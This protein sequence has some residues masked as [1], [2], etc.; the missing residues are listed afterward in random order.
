[1]H[2]IQRISGLQQKPDNKH[3]C[4]SRKLEQMSHPP[5]LPT[6]PREECKHIACGSN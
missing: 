3:Q 2:S 6:G 4:G 1:M 5:C